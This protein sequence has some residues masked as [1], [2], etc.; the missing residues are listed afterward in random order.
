MSS[1]LPAGKVC[2]DCINISR[3]QFLVG[4]SPTEKRC[5]WEPSRFVE[6]VLIINNADGS[7][8]E[9]EHPFDALI[10][11]TEHNGDECPECSGSG[12]VAGVYFS[13]DGIAT[14][15]R[16]NGKGLI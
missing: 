8:T 15:D 9:V 12:Q 6:D 5:D 4:C 14:C 7:K 10:N 16:C 1:K 13:E 2:N 11:C 3:C